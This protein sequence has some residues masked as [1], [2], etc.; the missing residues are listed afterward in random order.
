MIPFLRGPLYVTRGTAE[1]VGELSDGR[2]PDPV[3]DEFAG[4]VLLFSVDRPLRISDIDM[5]GGGLAAARAAKRFL[6]DACG[7]SFSATAGTPI[8][9][10]ATNG[11]GGGA[12]G[13]GGE[14]VGGGESERGR[15][16]RMEEGRPIR[17][18]RARPARRFGRVMGVKVS[19][20]EARPAT[21]GGGVGARGG[22]GSIEIGETE[23]DGVVFDSKGCGSGGITYDRVGVS[24]DSECRNFEGGCPRL[25]GKP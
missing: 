20:S 15:T 24:S 17:R 9:G 21:Y 22:G 18:G 1:G 5:S 6:S 25:A 10:P 8:L 3:V 16:G 13:G 11:G 4:E 19:T 7:G 2:P 12:S 23:I 14:E